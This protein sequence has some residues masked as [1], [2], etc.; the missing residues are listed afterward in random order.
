MEKL[1]KTTFGVV[2]SSEKT[3]YM[4]N[5]TQNIGSEIKISGA[6]LVT[7][8]TFNYHDS[9]ISVESSKTEI[10]QTTAR[11][12]TIQRD[13]NF[14]MHSKIYLLRSLALEIF[15][16]ARGYSQQNKKTLYVENV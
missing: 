16:Y 8:K 13:E 14:C 9:I 1:D 6:K 7:G 5:N 10:A 3:N 11:L 2:I 12:K 4:A 15:S